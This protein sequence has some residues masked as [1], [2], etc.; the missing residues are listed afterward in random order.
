MAN[1]ELVIL[2][3]DLILAV[4]TCRM[5]YYSRKVE[6]A[7][8][9][10]SRWTMPVI[11]AVISLVSVFRFSG[12]MKYVQSILMLFLALLSSFL[13]HG[14]AADGIVRTGSFVP[15]AKAGTITFSRNHSCIFFKAGHREAM[16]TFEY[17]Q[18]DEVR[19]Y[20]QERS[21]VFRA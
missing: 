21:S 19:D 3:M 7:S 2:I 16:M 6:L 18:L 20:L 9:A 15:Y 12:I 10:G 14:L 13:K 11:Y 1:Y 5:L 17:D 8:L 4:H